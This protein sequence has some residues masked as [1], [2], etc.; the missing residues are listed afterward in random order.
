[1]R[2]FVRSTQKCW[3]SDFDFKTFSPKSKFNI[4][5]NLLII[6]PIF[7]C[8]ILFKLRVYLGHWYF[9]IISIRKFENW[10]S[11]HVM[12]TSCWTSVKNEKLYII[13]LL[14]ISI[15]V[16]ILKE[17]SE[18]NMFEKLNYHFDQFGICV[19]YFGQCRNAW[20]LNMLALCWEVG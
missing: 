1:M 5:Q 11:S 8:N 17:N 9:L 2:L 4:L 7:N 18:N 15:S 16:G 12:L 14:H 20:F 6:W 3:C 13:I 19:I 10:I